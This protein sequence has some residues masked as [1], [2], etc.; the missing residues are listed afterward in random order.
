MPGS[1]PRISLPAAIPAPVWP[2]VT[3]ASASPDFTSSVATTI[4]LCFLRTSARAGCSSIPISSGACTIR[5]L[6]G[7]LPA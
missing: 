4:E 7:S 1:V 2:A 3:T 5:A 6:A